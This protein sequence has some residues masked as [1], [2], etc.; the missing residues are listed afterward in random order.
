MAHAKLVKDKGLSDGVDPNLI[1]EALSIVGSTRDK[2][3]GRP[4]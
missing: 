2:V 1:Q 4:S 3:L